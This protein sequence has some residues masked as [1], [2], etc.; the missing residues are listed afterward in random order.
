MQVCP[1]TE[2]TS[3]LLRLLARLLAIVLSQWRAG[4]PPPPKG[5]KPLQGSAVDVPASAIAIWREEGA[6]ATPALATASHQHD[7]HQQQQQQQLSYAGPL[8]KA[9][10]AGAPP[11]RRAS[12]RSLYASAGS[13]EASIPTSSASE[14]GSFWTAGGDWVTDDEA[15]GAAGE[16]LLAEDQPQGRENEGQLDAARQQR[17]A[18]HGDPGSRRAEEPRRLNAV[19]APRLGPAS[20]FEEDVELD[21]RQ[22]PS[23]VA[24]LADLLDGLEI[25]LEAGDLLGSGD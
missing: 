25:E 18:P 5:L 20:A 23:G 11:S 2:T 9:A 3:D 12:S 22:L 24:M 14:A 8:I 15:C 17:H 16:E 6:T 1:A 21:L 7:G 19:A 10:P 4:L 13:S